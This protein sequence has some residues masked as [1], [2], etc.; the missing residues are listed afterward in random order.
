MPVEA[1]PCEH[2]LSNGLKPNT[3]RPGAGKRWRTKPSLAKFTFVRFGPKGDKRGR[4]LNVRYVP[5]AD[6][7]TAANTNRYSITLSA[8]E[9]NEGGTVRPSALAVFILIVSSNLVDACT[10]RSAGLVPLR[11]WSTYSAAWRN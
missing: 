5:I 10:G 8:R 3:L 11:I 2:A 7:C 6:S 4:S 9:R 1:V